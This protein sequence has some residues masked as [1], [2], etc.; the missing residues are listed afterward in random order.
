MSFIDTQQIF[1][2]TNNGLDIILYYYPNAQKAVQRKGDKFK[3]RDSEKTASCAL[4]QAPDNIWIVTDFGGDQ[5]PRNGIKICMLEENCDFKTAIQILAGRH[6][7]DPAAAE[8]A[9][10]KPVLDYQP[11]GDHADD[12]H[13]VVYADSFT[14]AELATIF[15]EK[16]LKDKNCTY[17]KLAAVCKKYGLMP[18]ASI[19]FIA[20]GKIMIKKPSEEYP[21]FAWVQKD[22]F[23]TYEPKAEKQYRF[24][25]FG[26]KPRTFMFGLAQAQKQYEELQKAGD[27]DYDQA[28]EEEKT[29][30]RKIKKL[31]EI[32]C[33]SGGSDALNLAAL[34]YFPVWQ[35]SETEKID[36]KAF[37][38][39]ENLADHVYNLPDLDATGQ[40]EAHR[41]AMEFLDMK[42]IQLPAELMEKNDKRGNPCKDVRDFFNHYGR[43]DFAELLRVAL[44]YC[45]WNREAQYNRKGEFKKMGFA[46][47]NLQAY[48]FL[49][50]NGFS[51]FRSESKKDGYIYIHKSGNKIEEKRANDIKNHIHGF[52]AERKMDVELRNTFY[53]SSQLGEI[54]LSNLP[55]VQ[56]DFTDFDKESQFL[57][58][59]N[60]TWQ[61][62]KN[63]IQEYKIGEVPK[64]VWA[65]EVKPQRV[66]KLDPFFKITK[67]EETGEYDIDILKSDCLFLNYLQQTSRIHWRKE[68]ETE[69]NKL[70]VEER[71]AYRKANKFTVSG[72]LLSLEEIKEQKQHLMNKIFAIGY[73]MHRY[74]DRGK[75]WCVYAMDNNINDDGLSYGGSGKSLLMDIAMRKINQKTFKIPGRNPKVTE[76]PFVYDGLSPH[77]RYILVDDAHQYLNFQFFFEPL[78]GDLTVNPKN[79]QQFTIPFDQVGKFGMSTNFTPRDLDPSTERRLLYIVF[80]DYYHNH[81]ETDDFHETRRVSDDFGKSL[82]DEFTDDEWNLFYNTMAQCLQF[83]LS[84]PDK[85]EPPMGNVTK[86]NL[87]SEM[88]LTFQAWADVYFSSESDNRDKQIVKSRAMKTF[89]EDNKVQWT[90]QKFTKALKAWCRFNHFT[91]NPKELTNDKNRIVARIEEE[92]Y[93][94]NKREFVKTGHQK[95]EEMIYIQ[96]M[97]ELVQPAVKED[98]P[99]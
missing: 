69:L 60:K 36:G 71:D 91:Y 51:R 94:R 85:I 80:S 72:P 47:N 2:A 7:V 13:E 3:V 31:T 24:R 41:M 34:D 75:P 54:S 10:P 16:V 25:Y 77:H 52:L 18:V 28:D 53:K 61:I 20:A 9:R 84:C 19:S 40:R 89:L 78:T 32:I 76:N 86:R 15:S 66:K 74:K 68:L 87:Q 65:D 95:T 93:D 63:G 82:F 30:K 49:H 23:K 14:D 8:R 1:D 46:F 27:E 55:E 59:E 38:Q 21:I 33:V 99:F 4:K 11:K 97:D 70:P 90:T 42:T 98:L 35:N 37:R 96:T 79:N 26:N 88:G 5:V 43:Y 50:K 56:V 12:W 58:F 39:L 6:G 62:T 81:G 48:N 29:E 44:P 22:W 64:Y 73:L 83:F 67:D 57:F 92:Y 45:F 17:S